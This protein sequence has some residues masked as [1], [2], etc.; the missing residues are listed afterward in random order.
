MLVVLCYVGPEEEV[1]RRKGDFIDGKNITHATC[2]RYILRVCHLSLRVIAF[3]D[4]NTLT[5]TCKMA[6]RSKYNLDWWRNAVY[7]KDAPSLKATHTCHT[8][9]VK[10]D[11]DIFFLWTRS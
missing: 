5:L 11:L 8:T 3:D 7:D 2:V 4:K 6:E 9:W 1:F 10:T